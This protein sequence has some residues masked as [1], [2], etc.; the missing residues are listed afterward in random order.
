MLLIALEIQSQMSARALRYAKNMLILLGLVPAVL[1]LLL[2]AM[3]FALDPWAGAAIPLLGVPMCCA[4]LLIAGHGATW[5]HDSAHGNRDLL[6]GHR[7]VLG[8]AKLVL[9]TV[10]SVSAWMIV[11]PT[12]AQA[13]GNSVELSPEES[14]AAEKAARKKVEE[15]TG[16]P[17]VP[18]SSTSGK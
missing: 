8:L 5:V 10:L 11:R 18:Y 3:M 15:I 1:W 4:S 17:Y 16:K 6:R 9:V 13:P 14:R 12:P 7:L 2:V